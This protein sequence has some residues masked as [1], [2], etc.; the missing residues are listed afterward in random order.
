[1]AR[2]Y[3]ALVL[4]PATLI[5]FTGS[6]AA[7]YYTQPQYSPQ[8]QYNSPGPYQGNQGYQGSYQGNQS[9]QGGQQG[10][11]QGNQAG[12][13]YGQQFDPR[14]NRCVTAAAATPSCPTGQQFDQGQNR[15]VYS[16]PGGVTVPGSLIG[17]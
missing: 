4:F 12:C 6:V 17:R 8:P 13:P 7:Q 3:A 14:Q 2:T 16:L 9:Y 11:Y 1:M 15:C 10:G 5:G